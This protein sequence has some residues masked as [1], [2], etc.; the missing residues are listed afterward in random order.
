[1]GL[2]LF[3]IFDL[4]CLL[5]GFALSICTILPAS[6]D[7]C[8]TTELEKSGVLLEEDENKKEVDEV[9]SGQSDQPYSINEFGQKKS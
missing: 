6:A 9:S 8:A 5:V 7:A 4:A 3:E 2:W 1:M